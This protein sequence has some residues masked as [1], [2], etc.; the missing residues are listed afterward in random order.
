MCGVIKEVLAEELKNSI[1]M[2]KKYE[3]SLKALP[4]GCL[5]KSGQEAVKSVI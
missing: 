2:Q 1:R 5:A 4:Q 3:R